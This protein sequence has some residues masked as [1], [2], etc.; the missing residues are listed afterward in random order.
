MFD[1]SIGTIIPAKGAPE[2]IKSLSG[3]GFE[4]Y[5][6]TCE[7]LFSRVDFDE[8]IKGLNDALCGIPVSALGNYGNTLTDTETLEN[9][10]LLIRNAS[11]AGCEIVSLFAGA[12]PERDVDSSVRLFGKVFSELTC[13]AED[14]GVKLALEN[15]PSASANIACCP[16]IWEK[17]FNEVPSDCLGLEW[18]PAHQLRQLIDPI[19]QLRKWAK[20]VFHVHGKDATVAQDII[21]EHGI[22]SGV[23]FCWDRTPGYGDSNWKDICTI[24]LQSGYNGSI[25]I[26]GY[27]DPVHYDD[28]EWSCQK[29]ALEYLKI[30]RGGR[31]YINGI[32]Y[33]GYRRK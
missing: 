12:S 28:C 33:T 32:P 9:I 23:T 2:T 21:R 17:L 5:E 6:V 13:M 31:E 19:P 29:E 22:R 18:E 7:N 15:C 25:D 8:Y 10:K 27:H 11:K 16:D 20:K 1:I 4:C 3:F 14:N 26:E 30:C 24:L